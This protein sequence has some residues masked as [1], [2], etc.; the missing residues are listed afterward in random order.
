M[1]PE[2]AVVGVGVWAVHCATL[3]RERLAIEQL[4]GHSLGYFPIRPPQERHP[5]AGG[6]CSL[7]SSCGPARIRQMAFTAR[8][9]SHGPTFH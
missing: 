6:S 1:N 3:W 9:I 8:G 5:F 2:R 7:L 4:P